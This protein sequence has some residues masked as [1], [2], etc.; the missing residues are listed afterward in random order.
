MARAKTT[1]A[2]PDSLDES[3]SYGFTAL[4]FGYTGDF[5]DGTSEQQTETL[6]AMTAETQL[7][8]ELCAGMLAV[9]CLLAGYAETDGNT[10]RSLASG[11][12]DKADAADAESE[13]KGD[14]DGAEPQA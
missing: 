13:Q 7:P 11:W 6:L 12:E 2:V 14:S 1:P 4:L 5:L 3:V 10:L 8:I 9:T